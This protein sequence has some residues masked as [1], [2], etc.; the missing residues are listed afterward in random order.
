MISGSCLK[1]LVSLCSD[2]QPYQTVCNSCGRMYSCR[3][4]KEN[5]SKYSDKKPKKWRQMD[6]SMSPFLCL[7]VRLLEPTQ[8]DMRM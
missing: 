4:T 5:W 1:R 7:F 8:D 6:F 2:I 3:L